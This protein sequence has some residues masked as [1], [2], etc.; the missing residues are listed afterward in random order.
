MSQALR[1]S[2]RQKRRAISSTRRQYLARALLHQVQKTL[3][4]E[5]GQKIGL[6]LANDGEI[7]T[8]YI[9]NFLKNR[10]ISIYL[11]VLNDKSLK[12]AKIGSQFRPNRFGIDEPINTPVLNAKRLNVIFMPLVGFDQQRNRLGMGGGFYDRT[13][14]F[15][16]QQQR[17]N[18]PK[19]YGLAFDC[20]EVDQL[21]VQAWDVSLDGIITPSRSF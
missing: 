6:F 13:L 4:I 16:Q 9:Q 7:D 10:G 5:R 18:S 12:F 3:R 11:P 15:K 8:V 20:Q 17:F 19:L 2:L 21:E 14:G 1:Q